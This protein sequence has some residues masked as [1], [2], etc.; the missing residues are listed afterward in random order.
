M[1]VNKKYQDLYISTSKSQLK[2][3]SNLVLAL[4]KN[5]KDKKRL[6]EMFRTVHSMKGAAATM[7]FSKTVEALH[8]LETVVDGGYE[9]P[10]LSKSSIQ[11]FFDMVTA[12]KDNLWSI[13][14]GGK[15]N[16]FKK[17][18]AS[19]QS[20]SEIKKSKNVKTEQNQ[21]KRVILDTL[22][23]S[24]DLLVPVHQ[25]DQMQNIM[26]DLAIN[27][28]ALK[29]ITGDNI[30]PKSLNFLVAA[31]KS[32][33]DLRR[34]FE[35][36]RIVSLANV[37][38]S[39]PYLMREL[40]SEENKKFEFTIEDNNISLDKGIADEI[41]EIVIQL[42]KNA[43]VHGIKA[44]QKNGAISLAVSL[45][46]D[47]IILK[48]CDNGVGIDWDKI[49]KIA[50]QNK[51]VKSAQASQM[52]PEDWKKT[53]FEAG[54]SSSEKLSIRAG[55][56]VGLSLVQKKVFSLNGKID[57][58][59][60]AG[61]GTCFIVTLPQPLSIFRGIRFMLQQYDLAIPMSDV[62]KIQRL[63]EVKDMN[64]AKEYTWQSKKYEI[65]NLAQKLKLSFTTS[66]SKFVILIKYNDKRLALPVS[67]NIVEAELVAKPKPQVLRT[68][69]F[70]KGVAVSAEGKPV[71]IVD[72]SSLT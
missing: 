19:L 53:I 15:E 6:E 36:L 48:V 55:R 47:S 5:P 59:S 29:K 71:L 11:A 61:Q 54:I 4:E 70:F 44:D 49:K 58:E 37:F 14:R 72:L 9:M 10:S 40:A 24:T 68:V 62:E 25:L 1:A 3:L 21:K 8:V 23:S 20:L 64:K 41:I 12:L 52:S 66:L 57:I 32:L 33:Q 67:S 35:N 56:G 30:N 13:E 51:V 43:A 18:L 39:L 69:N 7:G 26:D 46:Q 27:F 16:D 45:G 28:I 38:S 34:Q 60:N 63:E 22:R 31:D 17:Q 2:D 50:V 65:I 42:L